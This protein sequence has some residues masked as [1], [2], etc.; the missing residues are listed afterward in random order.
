M[1]VGPAGLLVESNGNLD[2]STAPF[3]QNLLG[4]GTGAIG[5]PKPSSPVS[6]SSNSSGTL[7][8]AQ[9]LGF[10]LNN[11][12]NG[13]STTLVAS[14]GFATLPTN[15]KTAVAAEPAA[16]TLI[17][18]GDYL[19]NDPSTATVQ[20]GGGYPRCDVGIDLGTE[21]PNNNGLYPA[22]KVYVGTTYAGN[23]L[24]AK[25]SFP[26]VAVAG[27]LNGKYA[28]FLV[29]VDTSNSPNQAWGIYLLQSN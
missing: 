8:T 29:G 6:I 26:A 12:S 5:L 28:I 16:G 22:A 13:V 19:S 17:Y 11:G 7:F 14:F 21:D 1:G 10:F 2:S 3:Y 4:A 25:Y 9:Y 20:K 23:G 27:Q 24:G 15:C 18:G